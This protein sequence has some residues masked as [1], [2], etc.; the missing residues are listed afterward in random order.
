MAQEIHY[1]IFRRQGAKGGWSLHDVMSDRDG[2]L[3]VAEA[4]MKDEKATGVKVVKET[5]HPDSGDYL[6]LKIFEDGH[7]KMK[8]AR[9]AEDMPHALPC[10]QPDDLYHYHARSTMARLLSDFLAR[11]RWTVTE[12]IHRAD[13]LEKLEATGT[14]YQHAIQKVAVA[15]ASSTTAPVQQIIKSLNDLSTKAIHRVYRD[16]REK[17]FP[18]VAAGR[19]GA[20]ANKLAEG[21]GAYILNGA[22]AKYLKPAKAWDEKL[23]LL[24][25]LMN[26]IPAEG[27]GRLLLLSS[28]DAIAAEILNSSASLHELIGTQENLG[29]A[30][31]T[32][33][34]LFS[35]EG[36][37]GEVKDHAG[38]A[39]LARHFKA[40]ELSEARTAVANR[41][42][43]ELKSVKRLSQTSITDELKLLR[44]V[45]NRLVVSQG[46]YLAHE[47]IIAAFTLRSKRLV[48]HETIGIHLADAK[49]LDEKLEALLLVEENIIGA[50]NK[51][52]LT[53]FMMPVLQSNSFEQFFLSGKA[54]AQ[55]RIQRLGELQARVRRSGFQDKEKAEIADLLDRIASDVET[56]WRVIETI[57][58]RS[59]NTIE[60][61]V[62]LLQLCVGNGVTEGRLSA[63][64]REKVIGYL[65]KPGFLT[66]YV[67][68]LSRNPASAKPDANAAMKDLM[69]TLSKAG[70]TA[71]TGLKNIAA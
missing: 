41:I 53:T 19:F 70:I 33:V 6:S 67:A 9:A 28:I 24:L 60:R 15:Q 62:A 2:A 49:E 66:G 21:E 68:H 23:S 44:K 11:N 47:D 56:R 30:L 16:T 45:A 13:A 54:P 27:P 61:V 20:L 3:R 46:K 8:V 69:D 25:T 26:D 55:Q 71:E 48:T 34:Q 40:D 57:E 64:V 17:R 50:E 36:P 42:L 7:T 52:Q 32:L 31:L 39:A 63:R 4:M 12:L 10:F 37:S 51:R 65:S 14:L 59:A 22:I 29:A 58:Q 35:G 5:Y 43:A 38:I 18:D 1:E